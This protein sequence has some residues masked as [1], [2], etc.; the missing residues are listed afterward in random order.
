MTR[1]LEETG[2]EHGTSYD[3]AF[4]E[5]AA[6]G[7]DMHGEAA[8]VAALLPAGARVLDAGCG[9]GRV[10]VEL[11]RRGYQVTGADNDTSMLAVARTHDE[12]RWFD[13]DLATLE[14]GERFDLVVAAGNVMVFLAPDSGPGVLAR[15]A[16]HL[17]PGGLLVSGWR[18]DRLAVATYDA[19][20]RAAG[21]AEMA[22]LANWQGELWTEDA[23]WCVA[24]DRLT[25][26]SA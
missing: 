8:Y 11:A 12:I 21:L 15:L 24:V 3:E 13:A 25:P 17:E 23:D 26:G 10:A 20:A 14:L 16:A 22:R 4:R 1:W 18:T 5:L 9:T 7:I 2:G 19:W 6:Q